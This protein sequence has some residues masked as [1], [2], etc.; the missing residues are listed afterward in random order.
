MD[1]AYNSLFKEISELQGGLGA[2]F[3]AGMLRVGCSIV[4]LV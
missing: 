3:T 1:I 4:Y 2:A